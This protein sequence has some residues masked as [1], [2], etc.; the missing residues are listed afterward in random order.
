MNFSTVTP[1]RW[2]SPTNYDTI[3]AAHISNEP[4]G[5]KVTKIFVYLLIFTVSSLGNCAVVGVVL[6][7]RLMRSLAGNILILN[8]ALCDFLTPFISIPFDL[9]VEEKGEWLYGETMCRIMWPAATLTTTSSS[10]TL[11][12]I[13]FERYRSLMHPFKNRLTIT[14]V[15]RAIL[16]IHASSLLVV[17]PYVL[18]LDV[19]E[20]EQCGE[21]HWPHSTATVLRQTYT[22]TLFTVQYLA[23]LF[24]M[25]CIYSLTSSSLVTSTERARASSTSSVDSTDSHGSSSRPRGGSLGNVLAALTNKPDSLL[26]RSI[27]KNIQQE[28]NIKITKMFIIIVS[29]FAVFML[30]NQILWLWHDFGGGQEN[31]SLQVV[32]IICRVFTYTNSCV[33]PFILFKF[34]GEFRRRLHRVY[35]QARCC[36]RERRTFVLAYRKWRTRTVTTSIA[37]QSRRSSDATKPRESLTSSSASG[38]EP[39]KSRSLDTGRPRR[40][41]FVP[42]DGLWTVKTAAVEASCSC[43]LPPECRVKRTL[44]SEKH[45][46]QACEDCGDVTAMAKVARQPSGEESHGCGVQIDA[47]DLLTLPNLMETCC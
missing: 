4:I 40:S 36:V 9:A 17:I 7:S 22:V 32:A 26:S 29:I 46:F 43:A 44:L 13:A 12:V 3:S 18:V 20:G 21:V 2:G 15:K 35:A 8:L 11:A 23:P 14:Q 6:K 39:S 10:L 16:G 33:N 37:S 38:T 47:K 19:D 24:F 25:V 1:S 31:E 41:P 34:S 42:L 45:L 30:P 5:F 28:Q 27:F